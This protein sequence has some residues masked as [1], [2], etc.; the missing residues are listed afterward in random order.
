MAREKK[1]SQAWGGKRGRVVFAHVYSVSPVFSLFYH[2]K[3]F[4]IVSV[5]FM[6]KL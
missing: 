3:S 2:V 6:K 5:L 4:I 1:A